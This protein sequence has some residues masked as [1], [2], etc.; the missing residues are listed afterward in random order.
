M[1]D[2]KQIITLK[3]RQCD[4]LSLSRWSDVNAIFLAVPARKIATS[5]H[6][7][8]DSSSHHRIL[9]CSFL[10]GIPFCK[11]YENWRMKPSSMFFRISCKYHEHT[12]KQPTSRE[13]NFDMVFHSRKSFMNQTSMD[14]WAMTEYVSASFYK[15][16]KLYTSHNQIYVA[17]LNKI[18]YISIDIQE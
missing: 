9:R 8:I 12:S 17:H 3:Y 2:I 5:N 13:L 15:R 18:I 14:L 4:K 7:E 11:P 6:L 1:W 10:S 16:Y